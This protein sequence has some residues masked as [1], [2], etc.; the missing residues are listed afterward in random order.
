VRVYSS[1][2]DEEEQGSSF[3]LINRE[4][5]YL[6]QGTKDY[7]KK[8]N[9]QNL[10]NA[11]GS[12]TWL[13]Y[14][15][16]VS[17]EQAKAEAQK[18]RKA[19]GKKRYASRRK[20]RAYGKLQ[21]SGAVAQSQRSND[22]SFIW[23]IDR[24]SFWLSSFYGPRKKPNGQWGFHR[25]IDM[26]AVKGTPVKAAAGGVVVEA[27]YAQGYGKTVVV[28]HNA[29][30]KTRYAHLNSILVKVGQKVERGDR[31]GR[32]G[33]T[34]FV[35]SKRGGDASHLHLEV[36]VFGKQVNPMYFLG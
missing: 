7:L 4:L 3:L 14:T 13:D 32:V 10:L 2:D 34:G 29:K 17:Q 20:P 30:Y 12:H 25:G 5:E 35:R 28:A 24:S 15:E 19:P 33:A 9:Q 36:Y 11:L 31:V 18:K 23:P 1:D 22:M 27:R 26:A 21:E 6:K 16:M 8:Q